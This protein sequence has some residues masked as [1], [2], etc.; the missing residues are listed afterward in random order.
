[1]TKKMD[2]IDHFS[3][4]QST[5]GV[6]ATN[7]HASPS[8]GASATVPA[9]RRRRTM[10]LVNLNRQ[11]TSGVRATNVHASPSVG[12]SAT[13]PAPRRRRTMLLV[14]LNRSSSYHTCLSA[15]C[16]TFKPIHNLSI[17]DRPMMC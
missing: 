1:M 11:S 17:A 15:I 13:V 16:R 9:P 14:N 7:V 12:A 2:G 3:R 6:R 10:L 8:V 4:S 5:S